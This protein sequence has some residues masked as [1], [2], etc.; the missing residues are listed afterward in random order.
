MKK[1]FVSKFISIMCIMA[2]LSSMF[3]LNVS[4]EA[5]DVGNS[6]VLPNDFWESVSGRYVYT[7]DSSWSLHWE[8]FS[9]G[10]HSGLDSFEIY[11]EV[12]SEN[13]PI[14]TVTLFNQ[15]HNYRASSVHWLED[16]FDLSSLMNWPYH[17]RP[18]VA[19]AGNHPNNESIVSYGLMAIFPG[20]DNE[21]PG[22]WFEVVSGTM[23]SYAFSFSGVLQAADE[24]N[25]PCADT[26]LARNIRGSVMSASS[27][28]GV[29]TAD[30]ANNGVRE[31]AATNSWSAAGIGHEWLMV[32]FGEQVNFNHVRIYQG[33][34]RITDYRFEH[35][36]DGVNWIGFHSGNRI[37][38]ATPVYYAFT[39]STTIRAQYVR[40]VSERSIGVTPI[41][42]FEFEVY[43]MP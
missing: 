30:R 33:G 15:E 10:S 3:V 43:Y 6:V 11:I 18:G 29:R 16:I 26:N 31:G 27:V 4:A 13:R 17:N 5:L 41:V 32:D 25:L 1:R 14:L 19:F 7:T 21:G 22:I 20:L 35:S 38:E 34:N 37:L 12:G 23:S 24:T 8:K 39:N 42:V 9:S 28:Q 2:L 40:L 36:N